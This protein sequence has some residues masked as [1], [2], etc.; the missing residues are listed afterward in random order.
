MAAFVCKHNPTSKMTALNLN[1]HKAGNI[2]DI[3]KIARGWKHKMTE[4]W[5]TWAVNLGCYDFKT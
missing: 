4:E 5:M 2:I 3:L 1:K